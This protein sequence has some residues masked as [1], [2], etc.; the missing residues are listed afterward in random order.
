M[1]SWIQ[2]MASVE[3]QQ[4]KIRQLSQLLRQL[5]PQKASPLVNQLVMGQLIQRQQSQS[6]IMLPQKGL[7]SSG[8]ACLILSL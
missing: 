1:T 5:Q 7:S 4:L 2:I 6:L 8:P 3:V